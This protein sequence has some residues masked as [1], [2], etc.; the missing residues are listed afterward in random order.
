MLNAS[1]IRTQAECTTGNSGRII[2]LLAIVQGEISAFQECGKSNREIG[3][4][5]KP[6][7]NV[8]DSFYD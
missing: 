6:P 4:I 2:V 8:E 1:T 3:R 5:L 7:H